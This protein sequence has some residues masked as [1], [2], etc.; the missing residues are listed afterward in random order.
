MDD[1]FIERFSASDCTF[2]M[3]YYYSEE[4]TV[5]TLR[6]PSLKSACMLKGWFSRKKGSHIY[7]IDPHINFYHWII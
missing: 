4:A 6:G 2:W 1:Y 5:S 3:G 7:I